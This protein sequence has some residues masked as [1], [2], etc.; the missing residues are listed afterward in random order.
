MA[1]YQV[2]LRPLRSMVASVMRL[3]FFCVIQNTS[4]DNFTQPLPYTSGTAS[5][6]KK[7]FNLMHEHIILL[8]LH[9]LTHTDCALTWIIQWVVKVYVWTFFGGIVC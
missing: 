3:T 8:N 1:K 2:A 7:R 5:C 9:Y 6:K 4:V